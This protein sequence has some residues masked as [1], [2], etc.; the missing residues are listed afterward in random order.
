MITIKNQPSHFIL[1]P[2]RV[3]LFWKIEF[4]L[5]D[6]D[7]SVSFRASGELKNCTKGF[8]TFKK[9]LW[10]N[11][12]VSLSAAGS[13]SW[14]FWKEFRPP[15][16]SFAWK[17]GKGPELEWSDAQI[18][19]KDSEEDKSEKEHRHCDTVHKL[20]LWLQDLPKIIQLERETPHSWSG[21]VPESNIKFEITQKID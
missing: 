5:G 13:R 8:E 1:F 18:V 12:S 15:S 3:F 16:H 20:Y 4:F 17:R 7:G 19:A 14:T 11:H 21:S 10:K 6:S 9:I 2:S